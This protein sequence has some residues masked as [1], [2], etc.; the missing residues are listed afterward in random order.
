MSTYRIYADSRDRRSG[1][2]TSF[3]YALPYSLAIQ[4]ASLANI[5]VVVIPNSIPTVIE[6][7]N[8][9]IYM[10][11]MDQI[12]TEKVCTPTIA[13]GYYNLDQLRLAIESALNGPTKLMPGDY[14]VTYN[15][16]LARFQF[17][18]QASTASDGGS[19]STPR[20]TSSSLTFQ[21][22]RPYRGTGGLGSCSDVRQVIQ[23]SL[24][25][26]R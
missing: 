6:G 13:P 2:P 4:Q 9:M 7:V 14:V 22:F 10:K 12:G 23:L 24:L 26:L 3:E 18:T 17:F 1:S 21:P 25:L 19:G 8:D 5:D 16:L 20:K 15:E 11:E